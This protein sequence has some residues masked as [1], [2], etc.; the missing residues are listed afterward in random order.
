VA[1]KMSTQENPNLDVANRLFRTL[2]IYMLALT[3][4]CECDVCKALRE[5]AKKMAEDF[6]RFLESGQV[7]P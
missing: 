2:A 4:P 1:E 7:K 3:T 5:D 6:K